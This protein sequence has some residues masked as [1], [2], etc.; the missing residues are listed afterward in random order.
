MYLLQGEMA[1]TNQPSETTSM[2]RPEFR[3]LR[4]AKALANICPKAL[5]VA[6]SR[7]SV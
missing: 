5:E 3:S 2:A 1:P 4:D 6:C 7:S